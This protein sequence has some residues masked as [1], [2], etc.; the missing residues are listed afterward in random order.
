MYCFQL[1]TYLYKFVYQVFKRRNDKKYFEYALHHGM[2]LSLIFFTY[3]SNNLIPG[4]LC[5]LTHDFSDV[6]IA[7]SK[8]LSEF[9]FKSKKFL[10]SIY[11]CGFS[12]W[13]YARLYAYPTT[14]I[15]AFIF[16]RHNVQDKYK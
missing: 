11:V 2:A 4:I 9:T 6:F 14:T 15:W 10:N 8:C 5:M 13:C 12:I 7:L 3:T 1:G 16:L